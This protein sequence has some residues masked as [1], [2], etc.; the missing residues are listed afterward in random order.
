MSC[1]ESEWNIIQQK[2]YLRWMQMLFESVVEL[3][4]SVEMLIIFC[5][6]K[7]LGHLNC[8][9]WLR[10]YSC[11]SFTER[12]IS[13]TM[14]FCLVFFVC[15]LFDFSVCFFV[16]KNSL[17]KIFFHLLKKKN[18]SVVRCSTKTDSKI[19]NFIQNSYSQQWL[20][21]FSLSLRNP[22]HYGAIWRN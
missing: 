22:L 13:L 18:H 11:T 10:S 14:F 6:N 8:S 5:F 20:Y 16:W 3:S 19:D 1:F 21:V 12:F 9:I 15:F 7:P 17:V 2:T 4:K